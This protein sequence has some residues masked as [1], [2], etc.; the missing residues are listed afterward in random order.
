MKNNQKTYYLFN[1][2]IMKQ[3][4]CKALIKEVGTNRTW[5][6]NFSAMVQDNI[7]EI[8]YCKAIV[9]RFNNSLKD[10]E[11]PREVL[12][13]RNSSTKGTFLH[14]W[15]K[16]SLITEK[17]GYDRYECSICHA[18]GKRYGLSQYVTADKK[19]TVFCKI[20]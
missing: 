8:D 19:F 16:K 17:G 20:K 3:I 5:T 14:N 10:Y 9:E 11:N 7:D 1:V 2:F 18:T 12:H 6:E 13:V 15:K 4:N